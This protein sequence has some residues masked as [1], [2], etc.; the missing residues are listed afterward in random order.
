MSQ[1]TVYEFVWNLKERSAFWSYVICN[2]CSGKEQINQHIRSTEESALMTLHLKTAS[3][4]ENKAA[5]AKRYD[6]RVNRVSP[7]NTL[8]YEK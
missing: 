1:K 7:A 6:K 2:V 4:M 5:R 3:V 8:K